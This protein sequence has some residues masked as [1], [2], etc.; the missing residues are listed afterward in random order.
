MICV[1]Q[2]RVLLVRECWV[3]GVL[4]GIWVETSAGKD[5]IETNGTCG[6]W[7]VTLDA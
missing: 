1:G 3:C 6:S 2:L 5:V 7:H 4:C